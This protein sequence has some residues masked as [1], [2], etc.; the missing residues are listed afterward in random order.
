MAVY[1]LIVRDAHGRVRSSFT[2][3]PWLADARYTAARLDGAL[4]L[5]LL[6][7][8]RSIRKWGVPY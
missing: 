1:W 7:N 2:R 8:F 5:N 3:Q 4:Y 6:R